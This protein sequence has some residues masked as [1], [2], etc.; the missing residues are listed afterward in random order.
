MPYD[1]DAARGLCGAI[2]SLLHG[3]ANLTSAELA[4]AVGPFAGYEANREPMLN[5]MQMH[6][7]AVEQIDPSCQE[8]LRNAAAICGTTSSQ[9]APITVSAMP[10]HGARPD[11]DDQLPHGL[12]HDRHR[13]GHR[14]GQVQIARRRR[15]AQ[16]R[17]QHR[18][19]GSQDPRYDQPQIES[20]LAYI[21][22]ND[23]IEG[24]PDLDEA[25]L[26]VFDCAFTPRNGT[27]S[28]NWRAHI[29]M[30]AAAQPF[31]RERSARRSICRGTRRRPTSPTRTRRL[32]ARSQ[33]DRDLSRRL[34]G[35]PNR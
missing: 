12:R 6:R 1:S 31:L 8:Y 18:T 4:S 19:A 16:D 3:S 25:H 9:A 29:T 17:Q 28:I 11:R 5:V 14:T 26:P 23:T 35:K 21:E 27:R 2:T 15:H 32:A 20:I 10:R 30:M 34:E 24:S 13:T 33:G 7:D 22:K